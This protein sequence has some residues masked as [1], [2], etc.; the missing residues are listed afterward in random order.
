MGIFSINVF[1]PPS[2]L[3]SKK[4]SCNYITQKEYAYRNTLMISNI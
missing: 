3:P 2:F 4:H 1:L